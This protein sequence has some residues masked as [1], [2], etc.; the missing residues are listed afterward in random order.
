MNKQTDTKPQDVL[1]FKLTKPSEVFPFRPLISV[2]NF[3]MVEL[4]GLEVY[5]S[6]FNIREE[7]NKFELYADPFDELSFKELKNELAE[8]FGFSKFT[9]NLLKRGIVG[10]HIFKE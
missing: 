5:N 7:K 6:T 1:E 3:W 9:H 4:T 10:P 2:E 8:I